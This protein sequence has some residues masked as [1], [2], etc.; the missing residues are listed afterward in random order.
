MT[1]LPLVDRGLR[2]A[3]RRGSTHWLRLGA[4][5]LALGC[6]LAGFLVAEV[7]SSRRD[8]SGLFHFFSWL[9]WVFALFEG[10]RH[11]ADCIS[12][13]RREGTLGLLFLTDLRRWDIILGKLAPAAL[14]TVYAVL[15]MLPVLGLSLLMGGV[16]GGEVARVAVALL[17]S[18]G[19]TLA[20]GVLASVQVE[21][22]TQAWLGAAILAGLFGLASGALLYSAFATSWARHPS[23]F[24]TLLVAT[25]VLIVVVTGIASWTLKPEPVLDPGDPAPGLAGSPPP[26]VGAP[27]EHAWVEP[28]PPRSRDP[29]EADWL[30]E[31]PA[32]W[33]AMRGDDG[34]ALMVGVTAG[35]L[36]FLSGLAVLIGGGEA[37]IMGAVLP[38]VLFLAYGIAAMLLT[39]EA[40]RLTAD[41]RRSGIMELVLSTPLRP[42]RIVHGCKLGLRRRFSRP[43]LIMWGIQGLLVLGLILTGEHASQ[44]RLLAYLALANGWLVAELFALG[45]AGLYFGFRYGNPA[46]AFGRTVL[47]TVVLPVIALPLSGA[48][49]LWPLLLVFLIAKPFMLFGWANTKL[50]T[51]FAQ[52]ATQP[53]G[54]PN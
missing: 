27:V 22:A 53:L 31:N 13:E 44:V 25:S 41:L 32:L 39:W 20:A 45:S 29:A 8:G 42:E 12:V 34:A 5:G 46:K 38:L 43:V 28:P 48:L 35:F 47:W 23:I 24:L 9:A 30:A 19:L 49:C 33:L 2:V 26:A 14:H 6:A 7:F 52:L 1:F 11:T 51:D 50:R 3:A 40:C 4:A 15:A 16:T 54:T 18:V 37:A 10:L 36:L 17:V 21:N